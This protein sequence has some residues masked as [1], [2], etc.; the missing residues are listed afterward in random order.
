[1]L[2]G[3]TKSQDLSSAQLGYTPAL[4]ANIR[5]DWKGLLAYLSLLGTLAKYV[6]KNIDNIGPCPYLNTRPKLLASG[7]NFIRGQCYKNIVII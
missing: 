7:R 1:M 4:I 5:L 6:R 3:M 2:V